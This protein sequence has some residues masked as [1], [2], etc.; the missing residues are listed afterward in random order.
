MVGRHVVVICLTHRDDVGVSGGQ[1]VGQGVRG[2]WRKMRTC[3]RGE[4]QSLFLCTNWL[5]GDI[6]LVSASD[7]LTHNHLLI[8]SF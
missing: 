6:E 7:P 5:I 2:W 4:G 3:R 1:G 8:S